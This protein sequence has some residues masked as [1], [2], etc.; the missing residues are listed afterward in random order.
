M[1]WLSRQKQEFSNTWLRSTLLCLGRQVKITA[2]DRI[3]LRSRVM[4]VRL[5][6]ADTSSHHTS[7]SS[8]DAAAC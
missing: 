4:Q 8:S 1:G 6:P 2:R 5:G 7:R 3:F